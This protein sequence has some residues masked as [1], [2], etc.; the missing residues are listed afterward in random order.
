VQ[1]SCDKGVAIHIGPESSAVAREGRAKPRHRAMPRQSRA[2][3][4]LAGARAWRQSPRP[5]CVCLPFSISPTWSA[6]FACGMSVSANSRTRS[7]R[8]ASWLIPG[9]TVRARLDHRSHLLTRGMRPSRS[10]G[11]I[12]AGL[13]GA[14][15]GYATGW[16]S[17]LVRLHDGTGDIR[18][19]QARSARHGEGCQRADLARSQGGRSQHQDDRQQRA[20]HERAARGRY[21]VGTRRRH[22]GLQTRAVIGV[23]RQCTRSSN[24][25][26]SDCRFASVVKC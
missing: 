3:V 15:G 17:D 20:L 23:S 18:Q 16:G 6:S 14:T 19:G 8:D 21:C 2:P 22:A 12:G 10:G 1:V 25:P 26:R 13:A 4:A 24:T 11:L 5:W 7:I 9:P